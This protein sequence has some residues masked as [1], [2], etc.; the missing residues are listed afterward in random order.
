MNILVTGPN[1]FI[2]KILT[3]QL[4]ERKEFKIFLIP[5]NLPKANYHNLSLKQILFFTWL[6]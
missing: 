1:G 6:E 3:L 2:G 5:K 4:K